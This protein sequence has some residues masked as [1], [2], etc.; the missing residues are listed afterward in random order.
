MLRYFYVA[1]SA[2]TFATTFSTVK[3]YFSMTNSPGADAPNLLI[4]YTA[5]LWTAPCFSTGDTM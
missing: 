1:Y 3:P 5:S 2:F 4:N